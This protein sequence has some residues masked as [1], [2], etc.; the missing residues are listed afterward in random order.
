MKQKV[1][2]ACAFM[3]DPRALLLD[4]FVG[5]LWDEAEGG[6]AIAELA[7]AALKA[8]SAGIGA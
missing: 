1:A 6:E 4:G 7:R 5:G 3:H 8:L 2:L